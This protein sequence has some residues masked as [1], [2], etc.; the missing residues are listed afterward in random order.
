MSLIKKILIVV[1]ISIATLK[2]SDMGFGF[3][4]SQSISSSLAKGTGRSIVLRELNPNQYA[5]I[6]PNNNYMKDVENLAQTDYEINIDD[7]G[8]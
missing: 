1:F 2:I 6:R 7:N 8:L 3:I 4:Q 5:S